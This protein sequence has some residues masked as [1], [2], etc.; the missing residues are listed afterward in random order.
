MTVTV[1]DAVVAS[2]YGPDLENIRIHDESFHVK[3][4]DI[5]Q[6]GSATTVNGSI[7]HIKSNWWD[8]QVYYSIVLEGGNITQLEK[9]NKDRDLVPILEPFAP[10]VE[11]LR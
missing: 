5:R 8:D 11:R 9:R 10:V 6:D 2:V 3:R 7:S 4:V 1:K